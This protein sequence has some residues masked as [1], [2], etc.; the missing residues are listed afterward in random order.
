MVKGT[1]LVV[2][3]TTLLASRGRC[4]RSQLGGRNRR[5]PPRLLEG[6]GA[7][8]SPSLPACEPAFSL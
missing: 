1:T 8:P 5:P 4:R 3:L 7:G 2:P 6:E